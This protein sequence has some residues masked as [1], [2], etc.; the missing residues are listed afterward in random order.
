MTQE[1]YKEQLYKVTTNREYN[2]ITQQMESNR[3]AMEAKEVTLLQLMEEEEGLDNKIIE[4]EARLEELGIELSERGEELKEKEEETGQEELELNHEREK[5]A[6]RI[7]KP[8]LAHYE[9][10]REVKGVGAA[11]LYA[12]ACGSC[13]AVVPPQR[14]SEIRRM[15]DI[16]LCESCGVILLPETNNA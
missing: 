13:Y 14:Q 10:I 7:K 4:L 5:L 2:V 16:I 12:S 8:V 3:L 11:P 1:K 15:E 9:R 6:V